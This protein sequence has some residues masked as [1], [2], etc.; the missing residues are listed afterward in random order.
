MQK[1]SVLLSVAAAV[2]TVAPVI[3]TPM[4]DTQVLHLARLLL[5]FDYL[6]KNLY[7]APQILIEM[8]CCKVFIIL[9]QE[10]YWQFLFIYWFFVYKEKIK[11]MGCGDPINMQESNPKFFCFRF[12]G[13]CFNPWCNVTVRQLERN[14]V[15]QL[16]GRCI[17]YGAT[18]RRTLGR[19][20]PVRT[21]HWGR[22]ST[23]SHLLTP[24]LRTL[25]SWMDW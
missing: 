25:P 6:M 1:K 24:T 15:Q 2:V 4:K 9:K 17:T 7:E 20:T 8:V 23:P 18:L 11:A 14:K 3:N 16:V 22:V 21:M 19:I 5:I 13:I 12:S 10:N